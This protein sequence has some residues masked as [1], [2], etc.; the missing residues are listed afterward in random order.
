MKRLLL[1]A[2]LMHLAVLGRR[3]VLFAVEATTADL[4]TGEVGGWKNGEKEVRDGGGGNND[5]S[6]EARSSSNYS[7]LRLG[8][9]NNGKANRDETINKMSEKLLESLFE[10]GPHSDVSPPRASLAAA[11]QSSRVV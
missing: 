2:L 7:T 4:A 11:R 5:Q 8:T 10:T 9:S 6:G 1:K 3:G